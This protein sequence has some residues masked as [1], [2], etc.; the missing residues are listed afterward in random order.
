MLPVR[1][2]RWQRKHG[3]PRVGDEATTVD[4]ESLVARESPLAVQALR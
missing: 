4:G 3:S 2:L 1:G